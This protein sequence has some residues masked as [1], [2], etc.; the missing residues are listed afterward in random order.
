MADNFK[1]EAMNSVDRAWLGMDSETNLMIINSLLIFDEVV[2]YERFRSTFA[3]RFANSFD[4]FR[5]RLTESPPG[6]GSYH[7]EDYPCFDI[8]AHVRRIVLPDPGDTAMLQSLV[9]DLMANDLDHYKPLWCA[10]LIEGYGEGS[11]MFVRFHHCI[12]DGIALIRVMLS[13][14]DRERNPCFMPPSVQTASERPSGRSLLDTLRPWAGLTR[15]VPSRLIHAIK[16]GGIILVASAAVITRLIVFSEDRASV[17][18]G[19]LGTKKLVVWSEPFELAEVKRIG[20]TLG[21][22][23][24]DVLTSALTG[25]LRDYMLTVDDD[26]GAGDL[27]AMVPVNLRPTDAPVELGNQ[28]GLGYLSLPISI[29]DPLQRLYEVKRRMNKL[30]RSPEAN[31]TYRVLKLLGRLPGNIATFA[32]NYFATK[33]SAVLTN[34][35]GPQEALY[36]AGAPLRQLIFWAPQSGDIGLGLSVISYNGGIS[37]GIVVDEKLVTDPEKVITHYMHELTILGKLADKRM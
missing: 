34:V 31:I 17:F 28:F 14:T 33:A 5:Q 20:K 21:A 9:S 3:A 30:K 25:A 2:D 29:I 32:T 13:M 23:V 22:T 24:N 26:L 7:W 16:A 6:S 36:L 10:Y 15:G 12:A 19:D 4:R 11:A 8:G 35:P 37:V 18:S 1:R 27:R